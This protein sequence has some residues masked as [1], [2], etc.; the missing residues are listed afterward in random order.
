MYRDYW[1]LKRLPFNNVPDTLFFYCSKSHE[2]A[3]ARILYAA[4]MGKGIAVVTGVAGCGKTLLGR[5]TMRE[6]AEERF[7]TALIA[8]PPLEPLEFV[9]EVLF[10]FGMK[11]ASDNKAKCLQRLGE[12]LRANS[13]KKRNTLLI[14]DEAHAQPRA[15]MDEARFLMNFQTDHHFLITMILLGQPGLSERLEWLKQRTVIRYHLGPFDFNDTVHYILFRQRRAGGK[16]NVFN[17]DAMERIHDYS[18]GIPAKIN[19]LCDLSLFEGFNSKEE[20]VSGEVVKRVIHD[21]S[22]FR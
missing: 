7:D 13:G 1:G 18:G 12:R 8:A 10:Q 5:V 4:R 3:V 20:V 14:I 16:T 9:Q 21:D 6:L 22:L 17:R 19:D 2:E 11:D 15:T